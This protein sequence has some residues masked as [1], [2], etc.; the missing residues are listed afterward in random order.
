[1]FQTKVVEKLIHFVFNNF[2]P[3][4]RAIYAIMWKNI[5]EP[6]RPQMTI[7]HM[8]IACGIPKATN[9]H[10]NCVILIALA[11]VQW[12]HERA[13]MFGYT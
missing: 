1:M 13:S 5:V 2:P 11:L 7:R 8:C 12:F 4:N 3:L 10:T 6:G 9:T